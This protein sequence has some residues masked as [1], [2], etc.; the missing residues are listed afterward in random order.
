MASAD[1][2]IGAVRER[3]QGGRD[4]MPRGLFASSERPSAGAKSYHKPI[5]SP[6]PRSPR[7]LTR[8]QRGKTAPN[9]KS[10]R[11]RDRPRTATRAWRPRRCRRPGRRRANRPKRS[12]RIVP[13]TRGTRNQ[14]SAWCSPALRWEEP[15][16]RS[17]TF[18]RRCRGTSDGRTPATLVRGPPEGQ[19][20]RTRLS[21]SATRECSSISASRSAAEGHSGRNDFT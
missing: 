16:A 10:S 3:H 17:F 7:S 15:G 18:L 21:I 20:R 1:S 9:E 12:L 8:R 11:P 5:C 13:C 19:R 2:E 4:G 14:T 6:G